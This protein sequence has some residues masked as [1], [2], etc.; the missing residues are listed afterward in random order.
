[1]SLP[2]LDGPPARRIGRGRRRQ[3][4]RR[5]RSGGLKRKGRILAPLR[6]KEPTT[7]SQRAQRRQKAGATDRH[8]SNTEK[9]ERAR[10]SPLLSRA[11]LIGVHPWLLPSLC[12]L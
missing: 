8:G 5:S 10:P 1:P 12:P 11:V 6:K 7:K 9:E 3:Q 4:Y 2:A